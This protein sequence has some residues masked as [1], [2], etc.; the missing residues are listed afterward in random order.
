[1]LQQG[2]FE[3]ARSTLLGKLEI[4]IKGAHKHHNQALIDELEPLCQRW[5]DN[6]RRATC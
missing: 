2:D 4:L 1:V 3:A 6:S 5:Q